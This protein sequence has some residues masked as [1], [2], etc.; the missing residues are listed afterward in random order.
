MQTQFSASKQQP[1]QPG[2][3]PQHPPREQPLKPK[4]RNPRRR[5]ASVPFLLVLLKWSLVLAAVI[6][7]A[8]NIAP[9]IFVVREFA[10]SLQADV[11]C[12][13]AGMLPFLGPFLAGGCNLIGS[14][15]YATSGFL[16][17][18]AFQAF[19]LVPIA[20]RFNVPF[21]SGILKKMEEAPQVPENEAD[22]GAVVRIKAGINT[23]SDRSY[24]ALMRF[25]W[26]VYAFDL[27]LMCWL[28]PPLQRTGEFNFVA[29]TLVLLGVFGV[30]L[31]LGLLTILN[32]VI[33]PTSIQ[34]QTAK[35]REVKEY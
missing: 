14:V 9:Y 24:D 19:E 12:R 3:Q 27:A 15:F 23:V 26:L 16:L 28:Y 18:W 32:N 17:W 21:M 30:E 35:Q 6:L 5:G 8:I 4:G 33:D 13:Q 29:F 7:M 20:S 10:K 25:S 2:P 34:H 22:R 1:Q 31:V 11:V